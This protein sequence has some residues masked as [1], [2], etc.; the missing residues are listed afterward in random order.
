M[1]GGVWGSF[2]TRVPLGSA[3]KVPSTLAP[4]RCC[5]GAAEPLTCYCHRPE[6]RGR[7]RKSWEE[8]EKKATGRAPCLPRRHRLLPA[9][10]LRGTQS[11]PPP[12]ARGHNR[13]GSSH[14]S[15]ARAFPTSQSSRWR[16]GRFSKLCAA[17]ATRGGRER[18]RA[19][20]GPQLDPAAQH[21]TPWRRAR[22]GS[23]WAAGG[24]GRG[25]K[26]ESTGMAS[27][28]TCPRPWAGPRFGGGGLKTAPR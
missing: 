17:R 18:S 23:C 7:A 2:S 19:G 12:G 3:P 4:Q 15:T 20:L 6:S 16:E 5:P 14:S 22:A 28:K 26:G 24:A 1:G 25:A 9:L 11:P 21:Q 27:L 8:A 13:W 10:R